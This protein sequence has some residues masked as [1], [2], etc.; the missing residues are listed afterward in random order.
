MPSAEDFKLALA[1]WKETIFSDRTAKNIT[2]FPGI[3][4]RKCQFDQYWGSSDLY[5]NKAK[6]DKAHLSHE[7]DKTEVSETV[8]LSYSSSYV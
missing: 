4:S 2:G 5:E 6:Q 1:I 7:T 8:L 3:P